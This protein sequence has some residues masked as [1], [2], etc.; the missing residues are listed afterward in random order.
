MEYVRQEEEMP[1]NTFQNWLLGVS[2]A[3]AVSLTGASFKLYTDVEVLK[4]RQKRQEQ[5]VIQQETMVELVQKLDKQ[6]A[7]N[8]QALATVEKALDK[9]SDRIEDSGGAGYVSRK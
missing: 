4:D 9:L 1:Q 2:S 3:L 6:V 5:F 7:L 8:N